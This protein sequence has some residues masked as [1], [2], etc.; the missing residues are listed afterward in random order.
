MVRCTVILSDC[1]ASEG[2]HPVPLQQRLD[3]S[4]RWHDTLEN[5][6]GGL[7]MSLSKEILEGTYA[8]TVKLLNA[9]AP[10][11]VLDEYGCTP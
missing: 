9:G 4:L 5:G 8:G 7:D 3:A 10:V 2:W 11:N 6:C 1:H